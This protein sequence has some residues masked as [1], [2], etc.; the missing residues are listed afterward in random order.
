MYVEVKQLMKV[1]PQNPLNGTLNARVFFIGH[2]P[3]DVS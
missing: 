2:F 1:V 3:F